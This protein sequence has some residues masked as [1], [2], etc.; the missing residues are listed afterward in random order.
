[1]SWNVQKD[2]ERLQMEFWRLLHTAASAEVPPGSG[3]E[4]NDPSEKTLELAYRRCD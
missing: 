2:L 4:E 1:M 3:A